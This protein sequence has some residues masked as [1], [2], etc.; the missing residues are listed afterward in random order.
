MYFQILLLNK[1]EIETGQRT[2]TKIFHKHVSQDLDNLRL[3]DDEK[4]KDNQNIITELIRC[5]GTTYIAANVLQLKL[6]RYKIFIT[7]LVFI[8]HEETNN[9]N[10]DSY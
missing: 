3:F 2:R 4:N 7:L 5:Q 9:I 1:R 6:S 8:Y 10:K